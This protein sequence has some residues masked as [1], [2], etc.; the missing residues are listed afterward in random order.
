[1]ANPEID[2]KFSRRRTMTL[3]LLGLADPEIDRLAEYISN[4][5]PEGHWTRSRLFGRAIGLL[6][7]RIEGTADD[8][9]NPIL[10]GGLEIF[11]DFLKAVAL[12]L[13]HKPAVQTTEV[14][15]HLE[16][17]DGDWIKDFYAA[18]AVRITKAS[19]PAAELD[20]IKK[21]FCVRIE[22]LK[23]IKAQL[24]AEHAACKIPDHPQN[25][26]TN[27]SLVHIDFEKAKKSAQSEFEG[28]KRSLARLTVRMRN[29]N[30]MLETRRLSR[31]R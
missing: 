6:S 9:S 24:E 17:S 4:F 19:D 30:D 3:E 11:T 25:G 21:E 15:K 26:T 2:P 10:S 28:M 23:F 16:S 20:K 18:A 12:A 22:L 29:H 27:P 14:M 8:I 13:G 7:G 5:I 31:S 1:M